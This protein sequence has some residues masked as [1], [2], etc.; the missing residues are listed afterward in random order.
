MPKPRANKEPG[1]RSVY[2]FSRRQ[3]KYLLRRYI[4]I[5][6]ETS[7]WPAVPWETSAE[8]SAEWGAL[9]TSTHWMGRLQPFLWNLEL[10]EN[11]S[12]LQL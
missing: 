1:F 6:R 7:S 3:S 5:V 9:L 2:G 11:P 12:L 8:W 10:L 4:W